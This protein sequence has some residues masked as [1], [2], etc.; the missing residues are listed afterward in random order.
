MP[1]RERGTHHL[2][3]HVLAQCRSRPTSHY[4][5]GAGVC[6]AV[7][8]DTVMSGD[9]CREITT[10]DAQFWRIILGAVWVTGW[11]TV[12]ATRRLLQDVSAET[13]A[14]HDSG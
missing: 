10:A 3:S 13:K 12:R 2:H 4:V 5:R 9:V 1:L 11:R 6:S 14:G 8:L 7:L